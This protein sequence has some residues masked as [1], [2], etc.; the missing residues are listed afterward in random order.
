MSKFRKLTK[1][2]YNLEGNGVEICVEYN[3]DD[4]T[5][6]SI[7]SATAVRFGKRDG[8]DITDIL[9]EHLG[10]DKIVDSIDWSEEHARDKG[11]DVFFEAARKI[12]TK[13]AVMY[14]H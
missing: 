9:T 3:V 12:L 4:D 2:L 13:H 10:L 5:V 7:L 11:D 1:G 8:I 14:R 6:D